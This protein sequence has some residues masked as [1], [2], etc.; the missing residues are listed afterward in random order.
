MI[1]L[2]L[3]IISDELDVKTVSEFICNENGMLNKLLMDVMGIKF[4][5]GAELSN[6]FAVSHGWLF[7]LQSAKVSVAVISTPIPISL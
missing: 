7:F 1:L 4:P 3:K 5:K 2:K 6:D